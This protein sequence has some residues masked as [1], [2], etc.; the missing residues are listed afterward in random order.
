MNVDQWL[1]ENGMLDLCS[2]LTSVCCLVM[3]SCTSVIRKRL[4]EAN[5]P[6]PSPLIFNGP[7]LLRR[8]LLLATQHNWSRFPAIIAYLSLA[9]GLTSFVGFLVL[10][11][12][13]KPK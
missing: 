6:T 2:F 3:W 8:Y 10:L 5:E 4:Q 11:L 13:H 9:C 12:A 7:R 1:W